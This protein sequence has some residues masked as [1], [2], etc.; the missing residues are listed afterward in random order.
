MVARSIAAAVVAGGG[1]KNGRRRPLHNPANGGS[2]A[3]VRV[4]EI[5]LSVRQT[6]WR[7]RRRRRRSDGG[8]KSPGNVG[9]P[10]AFPASSTADGGGARSGRL[11]VGTASG[12]EKM[13]KD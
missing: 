3:A 1:S 13:G 10:A 11:G 6:Q 8:G 9:F 12:R 7:V 2:T 5:L 4:G